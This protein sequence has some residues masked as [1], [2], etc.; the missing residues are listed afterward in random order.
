M[1]PFF[2]PL[3]MILI[4]FLSCNDG[5]DNN[6][7]P[8]E[9][10]L[11]SPY[12]NPVW[13]PSGKI[14]GFN[15]K[16]IK[17]IHYYEGYD[18]PFQADYI[19][20]IDSN[21]FW[22]VNIDGTKQ[23]RV[24]PFILVCPAW[25]PD[26]KWI[27]FSNKA[28][29]CIMPFDG[30]HFDTTAIVFLTN[31]GRN[32]YP[33]W[34]PDGEWITFDSDMDSP[35]G[36][37]FIWKMRNDGSL[38]KRIVYTPNIGEVRMPY[39]GDNLTILHRRYTNEGSPEIFKMDSSGNNIVQ[40]TNN[41]D[42][43][44]FPACSN[45][46]NLIGYISQSKQDGDIELWRINSDGTLPVQLTFNGCRSYSWSSGEEIVYLNFNGNRID[47]TNGTLWIMNYNGDK[48]RQLTYNIIKYY[49]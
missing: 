2:I 4:T 22:L 9:S 11:E 41:E 44:K 27:A 19:Y 24:L 35:T 10:G 34:S 49:Q 23:R 16:P 37:K 36:L 31:M 47:E 40:L 1:R 48:K 6:C 7:S 3:I 26:G 29:I 18:C 15:H 25:S 32:F 21:G 20:D 8:F 45:N 43:E 46:C 13:H 5:N 39:W 17:E 30:E 33:S 38:K 14:I 12:N 28:Q 42:F